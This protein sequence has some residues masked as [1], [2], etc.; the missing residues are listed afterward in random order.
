[1][2]SAVPATGSVNIAATIATAAHW[3][4]LSVKTCLAILSHAH[5][6]RNS[7]T[8]CQPNSAQARGIL[9]Q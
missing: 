7:E 4:R 3:A 8:N 2:F 6:I 1:M 9:D 5:T